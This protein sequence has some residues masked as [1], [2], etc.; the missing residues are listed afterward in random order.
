MKYVEIASD[1]IKGYWNDIAS[2]TGSIEACQVALDVDSKIEE[3]IRSVKNIMDEALKELEQNE[4]D[5][6]HFRR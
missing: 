3:H 4:S 1:I 6:S 5:E 2:Q